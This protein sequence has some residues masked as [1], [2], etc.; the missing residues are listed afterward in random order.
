MTQLQ[1]LTQS[2]RPPRAWPWWTLLVLLCTLISAIHYLEKEPA[3][4]LPDPARIDSPILK[5]YGRYLMGASN[6]MNWAS[7]GGAGAPPASAPTFS[8]SADALDALDDAAPTIIEKIRVVPI[9]AE[10]VGTDAAI[11]RL[12][13]IDS[14][15]SAEPA[16][17]EAFRRDAAALRAIYT[18]HPDTLEQ[19]QR[20]ELAARHHWFAR[21]ALS[22]GKPDSD[23]E[24]QSFAAE[25]N[26]AML[27]IIALAIL[28]L[29]AGVAGFVLFIIAAVLIGAGRIRPALAAA[30]PQTTPI[31]LAA[32]NAFLESF[33]LFLA[34]FLVASGVAL[35]AH[36]LTGLDLSF[37][38]L[39]IVPVLAL[40]PMSRGLSWTQLRDDLGW[41]R[42]KGI[43]REIA[44][45]ITGYLAGIPII[46]LGVVLSVLII[47]L[48][49]TDATHPIVNEL[50]SGGP[51]AIIVLFLMA[52]VWAPLVE[53]TFFRGALYAHLRGRP[54]PPSPDSITRAEQPAGLFARDSATPAA[55][56]PSQQAE[57]AHS[58]GRRRA[59]T[60]IPA[61]LI[62]GF[63]FAA[64]H[65]QGIG[66]VPVLT[67]LG[68]NFSLL[69]E[70]RGSLIAPM[71]AH[72]I[73][74]GVATIVLILF[75]A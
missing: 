43:V 72:A 68:F 31:P 4:A 37:V 56:T 34:A 7:S 3:T 51:L 44:A 17:D 55:S 8:Q 49:G 45:G 53:E 57:S 69:R 65:P 33:V 16:L 21:L 29:T 75:L 2:F 22:F 20:D 48:S 14:Q 11:Q 40:W 5:L 66:A 60:V 64:I 67:A 71:T 12:D 39:C 74:N 19:P 54:V 58:A 24:R 42:G 62:T 18:G 73:H 26:R 59:L 70:W 50:S 30:S 1:P 47:T 13:S 35:V 52:T 10:L 27:G 36:A 32:S 9:A 41:R 61:A 23:P 46:I 63:V 25:A 28:F 38:L 6:L 15:L